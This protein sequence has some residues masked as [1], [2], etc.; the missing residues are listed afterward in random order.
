[1]SLETVPK[2]I[3]TSEPPLEEWRGTAAPINDWRWPW[4]ATP[5]LARRVH[6]MRKGV[7]NEKEYR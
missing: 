6:V 3:S 7:P 5:T 1:M 2:W 4:D